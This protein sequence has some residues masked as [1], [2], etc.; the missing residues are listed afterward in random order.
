MRVRL[1][2][3]DQDFDVQREL[4]AGSDALVQD[5]ELATLFEAMARGD[6]FL[7]EVVRVAV[8]SSLTAPEAITYRQDALRD[9]LAEG[10]TVAE[11]YNLAVESI[12]A[13][14]RLL[15][16]F[17]KSPDSILH[18]SVEVL[19]MFVGQLKRLRRICDEHGGGFRSEAFTTLFAVLAKELDDD[20]FAVLNDHLKRLRIREGVLLSAQFG[21][22]LKGHD[23]LLRKPNPS[24]QNWAQRLAGR[25]RAE[26][27][28]FVIP[29]RDEAGLRALEDIRGRGINLV[30]NALAQSTDH[31]LGF[32]TAL[33][34]ELAFYIGCLNLHRRLAAKG[35][36]TCF[37]VPEPHDTRILS[38]RGLYDACLSLTVPDRVVG[39]AVDTR[40]RPLVVITGANRGGKSTFLRSVGVAQLMMQSG[41]FV[42]AESYR[43]HTVTG[44][45]SHFKREEDSGM[46]KGKLA[47]ELARMSDIADHIGADGMLLCNESFAS[48]NEREGS[49]I[50]V[51]VFD[52]LL[53]NHITIAVV[54][55]MYELAERLRHERGEQAL[56]LRAERLPD[57]ARTFKLIEALPLPTSYGED[58][59][60]RI[61]GAGWPASSGPAS[62]RD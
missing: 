62:P 19:E 33:R 30:A 21:A 41:M 2:H 23:Y 60:A 56:F 15:R 13:E 17:W 44:L 47:E 14:R 34:T 22:G 11:M 42:A 1:L 10:S 37:P 35:E 31:I 5:L 53:D 39:N 50:A 54:T 36:P 4:P 25:G 32:F 26:A 52:A 55:H 40:A 27:Y 61:F 24:T 6:E 16:G 59:Y 9:C 12:K 38:C 49:E 29:E 18:R 7:H 20:Y 57:R 51:Q 43:A 8:L 48:T 45:F 3:R 46:R 28:G 58:L